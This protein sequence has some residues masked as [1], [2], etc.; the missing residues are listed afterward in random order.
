MGI[1]ALLVRNASIRFCDEGHRRK[2]PYPLLSPIKSYRAKVSKNRALTP[3][4]APSPL[5]LAFGGGRGE[6]VERGGFAAGGFAARRKTPSLIPL[7]S[8]AVRERGGARRGVR[9]PAAEGLGPKGLRPE[10]ERER[11]GGRGRGE[12]TI[13]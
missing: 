13:F 7:P 11:G 1:I 12:G 6:G 3:P 4:P 8:P 9:A 2:T 10:G 5:P